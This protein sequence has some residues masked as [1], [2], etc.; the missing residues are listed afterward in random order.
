MGLLNIT[1]QGAIFNN[2]RN[3]FVHFRALN[4]QFTHA[5][6]PSS[7]KRIL[8]DPLTAWPRSQTDIVGM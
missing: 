5:E 2:K 6:G 7:E 8:E 1:P 3:K 4:D